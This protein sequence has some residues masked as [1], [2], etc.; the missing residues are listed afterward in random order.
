MGKLLSRGIGARPVMVRTPFGEA[1]RRSSAAPPHFFRSRPAI[2]TN[3]D[4][5]AVIGGI[6]FPRGAFRVS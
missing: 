4:S 1:T 3:V 6:D 5:I 2:S